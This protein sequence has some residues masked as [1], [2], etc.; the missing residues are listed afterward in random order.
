M[1]LN[2][3]P[4]KI[5]INIEVNLWVHLYRDAGKNNKYKFCYGGSVRAI[6][7][8]G[9]SC[10]NRSGTKSIVQSITFIPP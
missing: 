10:K 6:T 4:K 1:M 3:P 2:G 8:D 5:V 9:R 7:E